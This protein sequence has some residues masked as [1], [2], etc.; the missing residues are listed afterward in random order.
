MQ[1]PNN[2]TSA[3]L[4]LLDEYVEKITHKIDRFLDEEISYWSQIDES[5]GAPLIA[6]KEFFHGGGK[7]L[8]PAFCL[9]GYRAGGKVDLSQKIIDA[10]SS[11]EM[12]HTFALVHDDF[13]DRADTRRGRPTVHRFL[14][15]FYREKNYHGDIEHFAQ[16]V[17]ILAGD[18]AFTY[19]DRFARDLPSKCLDVYDALKVELFAGQQMDLDAVHRESISRE[20]IT[21][22]AQY[23]SGRYTIER[24]LELGAI[25]ANDAKPHSWTKFGQPL[26]EAFQLRDDILGVFGDEA[27]TGKPVGDDIREGKF[28]MLIASALDVASDKQNR[29]LQQR[30]NDNLGESDVADI[31]NTI[32][33]TGARKNVEERIE[34]LFDIA[35]AALNNIELDDWS[36][37][38]ATY[39]AR[40]VC[41]RES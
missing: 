34:Q 3:D 32:E 30:G 22:I 23:K 41:W 9:L 27:T 10:G 4:S 24:P 13:M 5:V 21:K 28:T 6:M 11:L 17:A 40:Y 20:T 25:L 7:R 19:A 15:T 8:R 16:S 14:D 39:L 26:G 1:V 29:I 36:R 38:F 33:E 37:E 2:A 35:M 18:F 31:I 12:L